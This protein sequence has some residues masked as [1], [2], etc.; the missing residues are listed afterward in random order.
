MQY[1]VSLFINSKGKEQGLSSYFAHNKHPL[2]EHPQ[3]GSYQIETD[4]TYVM[5]MNFW[6]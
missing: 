1:F 4:V 6:F 3:V 5:A 2:W